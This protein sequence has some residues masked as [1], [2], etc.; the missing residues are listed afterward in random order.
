MTK[1]L[2]QS[3][4]DWAPFFRT[5]IAALGLK[6]L[7]VDQEAD[8]ASGYTNKIINGKK[9]P[10]AVTIER[11]CRVLKIS[12]RP[13]ADGE[14]E[15]CALEDCDNTQQ[16]GDTPDDQRSDLHVETGTGCG[17]ACT[18]HTLRCN[19]AKVDSTLSCLYVSFATDWSRIGAGDGNNFKP[20]ANR[21][22]VSVRADTSHQGR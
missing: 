14:S 12:L 3:A 8:F 9:L 16:R 1:H 21:I 19:R 5:R 6:H 7:E 13:V 2:I 20:P 17:P 10:G 15:N 4:A 11:L 22:Q 18:S